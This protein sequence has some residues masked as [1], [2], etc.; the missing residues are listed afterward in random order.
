MDSQT[1]KH[2]AAQRN[3]YLEG[4]YYCLCLNELARQTFYR[5]NSRD[6]KLF[7]ING[8]NLGFTS[9]CAEETHQQEVDMY[10]LMR[11]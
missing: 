7:Y 1:K 4:H 8:A 3:L 2:R 10:S 9:C 6:L 5:M 11:Y